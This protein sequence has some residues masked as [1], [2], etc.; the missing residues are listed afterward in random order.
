MREYLDSIGYTKT[1][2]VVLH[3]DKGEVFSIA[4]GYGAKTIKE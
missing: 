4:G 2:I 3:E 1:N